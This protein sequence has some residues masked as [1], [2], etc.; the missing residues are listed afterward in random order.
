[1]LATINKLSEAKKRLKKR[2]NENVDIIKCNNLAQLGDSPQ[3]QSMGA[4]NLTS[5]N[6]SSTAQ[7]FDV[8]GLRPTVGAKNVVDSTLQAFPI[9]SQQAI[10]IKLDADNVKCEL[11]DGD[12]FVEFDRSKTNKQKIWQKI[13]IMG[14]A[15]IVLLVFIALLLYKKYADKVAFDPTKI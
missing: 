2:F 5:E 15:S 12:M 3:K 7:L 6:K 9:T 1:M 11:V 14:V 13:V 4:S 8:S 10:E